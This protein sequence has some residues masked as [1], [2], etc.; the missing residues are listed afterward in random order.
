MATN[1]TNGYSASVA[2][3]LQVNGHKLPIAQVGRD[4]LIL[5]E[6][7]V[8]APSTQAEIV[9]EVDEQVTQRRVL[10]VDGISAGQERVS[11]N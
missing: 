10:L 7:H 9:V 2:M 1:S 3:H 6:P 4:F 8:I 5:R 11:F